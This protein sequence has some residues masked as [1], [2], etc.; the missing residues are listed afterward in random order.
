MDNISKL[1]GKDLREW[2]GKLQRA[3]AD[4]TDA[5]NKEIFK[6]WLN[7][8]LAELARR[9]ARRERYL[10]NR[11]QYGKKDIRVNN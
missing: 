9:T 5:R 11:R 8:S 6:R 7:L 4:E 10:S 3:I 2:I 1:S